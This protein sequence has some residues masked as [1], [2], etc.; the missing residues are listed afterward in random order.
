M[1]ASSQSRASTSELCDEVHRRLVD[2]PFPGESID[3]STIIGLAK[4]IEPLLG[5]ADLGE[6]ATTVL[7]RVEGTG[8]LHALLADESVTD[9]MVNGPG[10][11]W[12]ERNGALE[13]AGVE[14]DLTEIERLIERTVARVGRRVDPGSP[15]ADARLADGSRVNVVVPPI[16]LDGPCVTIRRFGA[17]PIDVDAMC[18]EGVGPL[19]R[20]AVEA[21]MNVLI[22]GGT[23]AGKTTLLN[24]L[25]AQISRTER[26]VSIEDAA[27]LRLP[28]AHVVRLEA[29]PP[30]TEGRGAVTIHELVRNALRMRPDRIIVGEVRGAEAFDM[31]WAMNTGHEGSFSTIH[32]NSISDAVARLELMMIQADGSLPLWAANQQIGAAIDLVVQV[33]RR[34]SGRAVVDVG[35][36]VFEDRSWICRSLIE[37]PG[38]ARL[39]SRPSRWSWSRAPSQGWCVR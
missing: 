1:T 38:L 15:M 16:A 6:V 30:N 17:A 24:A 12:V 2:C 21:R 34:P 9:I 39:P 31:I 18:P 27:E 37:Q 5:A 26:V 10:R 14:I 25:A 11:V 33:E 23:G 32:A 22:S 20:W 19:L 3:R 36:L 7:A 28:I 8:P 13:D 4:E 35:E 29:R